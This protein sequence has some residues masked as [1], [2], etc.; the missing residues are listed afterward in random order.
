MN[1]SFEILLNCLS[2]IV[3]RLQNN[4]IVEKQEDKEFYNIFFTAHDIAI[5]GCD[6]DEFN[7]FIK[8]I[9]CKDKENNK[10][11]NINCLIA[12]EEEDIEQDNF[13]N[14]KY[15]MT[16][17]KEVSILLQNLFYNLKDIF[18]EEKDR[19]LF[20]N[21]LNKS[22]IDNTFPVIKNKDK[23]IINEDL[24]DKN[25]QTEL[26]IFDNLF[27]RNKNTQRE[28]KDNS[29][30]YQKII[31]Q[32]S[33]DKMKEF[34]AGSK[35]KFTKSRKEGG[36][37]RSHN[38]IGSIVKKEVIEPMY[39]IE[40]TIAK[41]EDNSHKIA[42]SLCESLSFLSR[43]KSINTED[44]KFEWNAIED[45]KKSLYKTGKIKKETFEELKQSILVD[46]DNL[47][48]I[49]IS[50]FANIY[51]IDIKY[52]NKALK[53]I[54]T[55]KTNQIYKWCLE[56]DNTVYHKKLKTLK[57]KIKFKEEI[58]EGRKLAKKTKK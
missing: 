42:N 25:E 41:Y 47:F 40:N 53:Y 52:L 11:F 51:K 18:Y 39:F 2:L 12:K 4:A 48:K 58:I 6:V 24:F 15:K 29:Q 54:S 23:Y 57:E 49:L 26:L 34:G 7:E 43:M 1:L 31:T 32:R 19:K 37:I 8:F 9:Y 36:N 13:L 33:I 14:H 3:L 44:Y 46:K 10:L 17:E 38:K 22:I 5:A 35:E 56:L 30:D 27:K 20:V 50:W 28:I 55:E 45:I 21:F 16:L